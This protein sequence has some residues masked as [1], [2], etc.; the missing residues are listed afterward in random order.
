[1][2]D[3][4]MLV[5]MHYVIYNKNKTKHTVQLT[6]ITECLTIVPQSYETCSI[7]I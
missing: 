3:I 7:T 2:N 5:Q 4:T 6:L 1:M